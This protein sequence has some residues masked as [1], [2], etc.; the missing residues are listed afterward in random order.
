MNK[1]LSII[2]KHYQ[3]TIGGLIVLVMTIML[4]VGKITMTE[5]AL[6]FGTVAG[7][8]GLVMKDPNKVQS[9]E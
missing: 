3:T 5:W 6:G 8:A 2:F 7:I 1:Y 4:W 9:K